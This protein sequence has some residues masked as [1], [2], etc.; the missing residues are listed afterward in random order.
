MKSVFVAPITLCLLFC[1]APVAH[2]G[3]GMK[4]VAQQYGYCESILFDMRIISDAAWSENKSDMLVKL[5]K[6]Q[7]T[8]WAKN[9]HD[10]TDFDAEDHP[11]EV[12]AGATLA[13]KRTQLEWDIV[14]RDRYIPSRYFIGQLDGCFSSISDFVMNNMTKTDYTTAKESLTISN[15]IRSRK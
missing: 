13:H 15:F 12:S 2:S 3:N 7:Y 14:G 11:E 1:F 10:W 5:F 4:E 6:T 9:L 8:L